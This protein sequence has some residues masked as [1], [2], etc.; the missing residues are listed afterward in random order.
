MIF[1]F[2]I[3]RKNELKDL[4]CT[5]IKYCKLMQIRRWFSGWTDLD[6]IWDYIIQD[7]NYGGIEK[8]RE[9]YAKARKTTVYGESK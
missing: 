6:I 3:I 8:A 5:H 1:G 4:Q 2:T 7:T 9:D